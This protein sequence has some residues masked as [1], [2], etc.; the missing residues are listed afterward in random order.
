MA[1][2]L[3]NISIVSISSI[4]DNICDSTKV[5]GLNMYNVISYQKVDLYINIA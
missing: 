5:I 3:Y 4:N 1:F 2:A